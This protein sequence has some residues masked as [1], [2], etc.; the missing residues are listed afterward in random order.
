M[1]ADLTSPMSLFFPDQFSNLFFTTN[2][3]FMAKKFDLIIKKNELIT[4]KQALLSHLGNSC[5]DHIL[6][7]G[8]IFCD[9]AHNGH[10]MGSRVENIE[11][12]IIFPSFSIS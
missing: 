4:K 12:F 2:R 3:D 10:H 9:E 6:Q 11:S 5:V 1:D 8:Q 7:A